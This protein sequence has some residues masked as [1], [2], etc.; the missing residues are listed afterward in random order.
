MVSQFVTKIKQYSDHPVTD[1]IFN[2]DLH[3]IKIIKFILT[4]YCHA[5]IYRFFVKNL[6]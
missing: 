3:E 4:Y 6:P 5:K 2:D 1:S